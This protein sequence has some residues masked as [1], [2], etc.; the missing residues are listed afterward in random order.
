MTMHRHKPDQTFTLLSP[1]YNHLTN[2][3]VTTPC[4]N[5]NAFNCDEKP[6]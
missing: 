2:Q 1:E 5:E 6:E 3:V 4:V